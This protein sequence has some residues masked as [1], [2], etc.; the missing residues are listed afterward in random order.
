M[1]WELAPGDVLAH[2]RVL[3]PLGAGAVGQVY[4]AE[5]ARLGRRLALKV[6]SPH[7]QEDQERLDRFEREARTISTLNHPN[8]LT[9]YDVGHAD[10]REFIATEYIDGLTLRALL[11]AGR[12][13]VA[14]AVDIAIQIAQALQAAHDA[15]VIHRDLKPENVM[16]RSDGYVKV[17]DFGLAK[18]VSGGALDAEATGHLRTLA[19]MIL[20]TLSYMAPEQARGRDLD[21]RAD[22]FSLGVLMYEML[23]GTLPF[24]GESAAEVIG[25]LLHLEPEPLRALADV[26]EA[27][28]TIVATALRKTPDERYQSCA[29][30]LLDLRAVTLPPDAGETR[31]QAAVIATRA[32]VGTRRDATPPG[33]RRTRRRIESIAVLPLVSAPGDSELDYLAEGLTESLIDN[34]SQIPR[35]RV[36]ARSTVFRFQGQLVDPRTVGRELNVQVVLT[37]RVNQQA[38]VFAVSTEL[39]DADDGS[40]LWGATVSRRASDA[41]VLLAAVSQ[42]ITSALR[43]RLT[44]SE[45]KRLVKQ[46]TVSA[47]AYQLYMRGRHFLNQRTGDALRSARL[48]LERAVAEDPNYALAFAGLADCC[49]LIAVSHRTSSNAQLIE[50]ARQAATRALQLDEALAEGHASLA[51]IRFRFDWHWAGAEAEFTR[52]LQLNPG[53]APSRQWHAMYLASRSRCEAALAEMRRALELDPLSLIIQS[54]IGRVLHFA[55]RYDEAIAQ[56]GTVLRANPW[57]AQAHLDEALTRMAR[58]ELAA[59]RGALDRAEDVLG[60]VSTI[61]LLRTCCTAREGRV[62]DGRAGFRQLR[63]RYDAGEAGADDLAMAA[64]A[65]G[66]WEAAR[67]WLVEACAQRAPFLVYVDVEPA[68]APLLADADCRAVLRRH[69]FD[70]VA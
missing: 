22:L 18:F 51:F 9:I 39:V 3:A 15:G 8:I 47:E 64:A 54:G 67:A 44:P 12:F 69:G 37:G 62:D 28:E 53:H 20:G 57:F 33:R 4:L 45:K 58:D 34:L 10:G 36:M 56:Y 50:A 27:L 42:E 68:M 21:S 2:Y 29:G 65:L 30:L 11:D 7:A 31:T 24:K 35:L 61:L 14:R 38:G 59:A 25:A 43:L 66:D 70:A 41:F 60:P 5:D 55:R 49:S 46:H 32:P 26:P 17:L 16:V 23:S 52:S 1:S 40:R 48:L 13:P 19:G 6:L 63:E